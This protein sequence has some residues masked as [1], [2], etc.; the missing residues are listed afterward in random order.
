M[1]KNELY[2]ALQQIQPD[3]YMKER[4]CQKVVGNQKNRFP[5]RY[6]VTAVCF[7]TVCLLSVWVVANCHTPQPEVTE[8]KPSA[9][10][11]SFSIRAYAADR[12]VSD[13]NITTVQ[14]DFRIATPIPQAT[15]ERGKLNTYEDNGKT[16]SAYEVAYGGNGICFEAI[17]E[18][19]KAVTIF[20]QNG[21]LTYWDFQ[22]I[23]KMKENGTYYAVQFTLPQDCIIGQDKALYDQFKKLWESGALD[24]YKKMYFAGKSANLRDYAHCSVKRIE[25]GEIEV[26]LVA[27]ETLAQVYQY[28]QV[29]TMRGQEGSK[30]FWRPKAALE[31]AAEYPAIPFDKL[32]KDT[33]TMEVQFEDGTIQTKTLEIWFDKDGNTL[34]QEIS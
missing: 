26:C 12:T 27:E 31:K 13:D 16:V 20:T 8:T 10:I 21:H 14:T 29:V 25:S 3:A 28:G 33:V 4:L 1:K 19:I 7:A 2:T 5:L 30:V 22:Q 34:I 32:P 17:G 18:H 6:A 23:D 24:A 11:N 15:I 9:F